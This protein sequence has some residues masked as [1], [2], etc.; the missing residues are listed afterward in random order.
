MRTLLV[1][2]CVI[3]LA[4]TAAQ[5]EDKADQDKLVC[6]RTEVGF[7]GSRI[8][9]P[10]KTCMKASEWRELEKGAEASLRKVQS[11]GTNA[12]SDR[13]AGVGGQ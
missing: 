6:K 8:G 1:F 5:A 3:A 10:K 11:G 9:R 4:S 12:P 13:G 2:S 7:T